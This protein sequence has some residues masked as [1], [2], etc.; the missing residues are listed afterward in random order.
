MDSDIELEGYSPGQ[1]IDRDGDFNENANPLWSLYGKEAKE[2]D[3]HAIKDMTGG[4]EELF[5]F[6]RSLPS[7]L[8]QL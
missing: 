4:I 3:K 5:L 2:F 6:V 7:T 1:D 8:R